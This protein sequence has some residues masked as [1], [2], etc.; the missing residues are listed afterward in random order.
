[1]AAAALWAR[2]MMGWNAA[3]EAAPA[4]SG[5]AVVWCAAAAARASASASGDGAV[6]AAA[7]VHVHPAHLG[8]E[9][10]LLEIW[11]LSGWGYGRLIRIP[12]ASAI[13]GARGAA[14]GQASIDGAPR[15]ANGRGGGHRYRARGLIAMMVS[16][17]QP[18]GATAPHSEPLAQKR[19]QALAA[20]GAGSL[21]A[22]PGIP[23]RRPSRETLLG[24]RPHTAHLRG[25]AAERRWRAMRLP[26]SPWRG[27]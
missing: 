16:W 19:A 14:R 12:I 24:A 23:A 13:G 4:V 10:A 9:I 21:S 5:A 6:V 18:H 7:P 1:M 26:A 3:V 20:R 25:A 27:A 8:A 17:M 22:R 11:A 2:S 15:R